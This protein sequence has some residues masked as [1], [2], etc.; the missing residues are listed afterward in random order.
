MKIRYARV[1]TADQHLRM[2][3]DALKQAGCE[4][5]YHDVASGA[6]SNRPGLETALEHRSAKGMSSSSGGLI[7]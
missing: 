4:T 2:Q 1:S 7:D 3:E 6:K 5:I